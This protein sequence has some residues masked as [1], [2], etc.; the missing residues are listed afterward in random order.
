MVHISTTA[1]LIG[2]NRQFPTQ[3]TNQPQ[4]YFNNERIQHTKSTTF[5]MPEL[6]QA[7]KKLKPFHKILQLEGN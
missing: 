1:T 4:T 3:P 5:K 7:K 6:G 2:V